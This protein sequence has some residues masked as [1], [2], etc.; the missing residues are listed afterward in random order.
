MVTNID[1][2]ESVRPLEGGVLFNE[3]NVTIVKT[4][5]YFKMKNTFVIILTSVI[6]VIF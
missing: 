1:N 3:T 6:S 5:S 4:D 2:I